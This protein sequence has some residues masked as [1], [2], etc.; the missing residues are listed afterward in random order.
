MRDLIPAH[1]RVFVLTQPPVRKHWL[2]RLKKSFAKARLEVLEMPDGERNKTL[3]RMEKLAEE[4]VRRGADRHSVLLALGGGVVGDVG[5]FL[6]S[7]FMR[8]IPVV[9]IPTTLL[10]QVDSAIGGKTGVNLRSGKNLVGTFH[11]PAVVLADPQV[12]ATLPEREYRS[13]LY[14]AMKYGVIRDTTIFELMEKRGDVLLRRD[15]ALLEKLIAACVRVKADVVGA[16]ERESGERRILNF[17]HTIGHALEAETGY[18]HFLHG[19]AVAWGMI[20]ATRLAEGMAML[21]SSTAGRIIA[22]V[23]KLWPAAEGR[24]QQQED[25]APA[26]ERQEDHRRGAA[27]RVAKRHWQGPGGEYGVRARRHSRG[28]GT[29]ATLQSMSATSKENEAE[30]QRIVGAAPAGARD[31]AAASAAV[32]DMFTSIAPRYDL[33][34]HVLSMNVDRLWWNRTARAFNETLAAAGSAD[35]GSVLRHRRHGVCTVSPG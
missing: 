30:S 16:D 33:L 19:E 7:V 29:E 6:A 24:R 13:G 20:A 15:P 8:G 32:R 21:D 18:Q 22:M 17:G 9:Q 11:Q 35:S 14:E 12:L 4:M 10:A 2:G 23:P 3:A 25:F 5:G 27:F 31:E 28:E 34:N 26:A 1:A